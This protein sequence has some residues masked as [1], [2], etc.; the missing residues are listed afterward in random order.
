VNCFALA[1]WW[2]L[3]RIWRYIAMLRVDESTLFLRVCYD[4]VHRNTAAISCLGHVRRACAG[5]FRGDAGHLFVRVWCV[6]LCVCGRGGARACVQVTVASRRWAVFDSVM[7]NFS[8]CTCGPPPCVTRVY[9]RG[10]KV[11][12][13]GEAVGPASVRGHGNAEALLTRCLR[14]FSRP[15]GC[16]DRTV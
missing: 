13:R 11:K 15:C 4:G 9:A 14:A 1:A 7:R 10:S 16:S 2:G 12:I 6:T 8:V 5:L 3:G